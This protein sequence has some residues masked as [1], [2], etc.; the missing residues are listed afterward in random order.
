MSWSPVLLAGL[1][2]SLVPA[3][4]H[5]EP[6]RLADGDRVVLVGNALIEQEQR[7]GYW[8]A[9]LLRR[10]P[11]RQVTFRNLGWSGDTVWGE[12][13]AGFGTAADGFRALKEQI[14]SLKPTVLLVGYGSN[15]AFAGPSGL[16]RFQQGLDT[17]LNM[18]EESRARLV[19]L[20]P[21]RQ[22]D[23]GRPLPDPT[24]QNRNLAL[25]RDV[26]KQTAAR[27]RYIFVDLFELLA[28]TR[29]GPTLTDDEIHLTAYGYWRSAGALQEGLGLAP[30]SWRIDVHE[31]GAV[32]VDGA[33]VA[34]EPSPLLRLR[35]VDDALPFTPSRSSEAGTLPG[36][37]RN[38]RVR[39]LPAGRYVLQIDGQ[40]VAEAA[41]AEWAKGM[42]LTRGPE[43]EH[44]E[45][46][47]A[48]II[49]KNRE[50]FYRWRPQNETYL[51]GFRKYEQGQN[52]REV[53]QFEPI[54]AQF[55]LAIAK[56][57][58]PVAHTYE[59]VPIEKR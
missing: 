45:K 29:P 4:A 36:E 41:A 48:T 22:E 56:L 24:E 31:D 13:R 52:A 40:R 18:L 50:Y 35:V 59:L 47:R 6:F 46:L 44:A 54:V 21:Q 2:A 43:F 8:E 16:P 34:K 28:R 3:N 25:Y 32:E 30:V 23:L 38:F 27:R 49:V 11:A 17:L 20:S 39:R 12:A 53:P 57:R 42:V 55:D 10:F 9:A 1:F 7:Y 5:A 14:T 58:Q 51:F 33:Q 26:L 19:L 15:E 37:E